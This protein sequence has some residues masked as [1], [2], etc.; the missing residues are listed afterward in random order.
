MSITYNSFI[1]LK[2]QTT[3]PSTYYIVKDDFIV[4]LKRGCESRH[5]TEK[6]EDVEPYEVVNSSLIINKKR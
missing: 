6:I 3:K 4:N 1:P 5:K 2:K